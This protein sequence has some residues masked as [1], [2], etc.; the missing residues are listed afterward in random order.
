[1]THRPLFLAL[2]ACTAAAVS[3]AAGASTAK[4]QFTI[5]NATAAGKNSPTRVLA[6]GAINGRGTVDVKSSHDSRIDHMTFHLGKGTVFLVAVEK[7]YAVHP[8]PTKCLATALG[9]GTFTITGGTGNFRGAHGS[10]TY[11]RHAVLYGARNTA[12]ACLGRNAPIAKTTVR[13]N[14]TGTVSLG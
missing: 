7:S 12:G 1:M 14:M 9:R 10:G 3:S 6:D 13:V 8:E 4:Q 5:T 2:A 11:L